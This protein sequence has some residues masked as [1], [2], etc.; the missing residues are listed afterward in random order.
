MEKIVT[1]DNIEL[2][3]V[4]N[5][6]TPIYY[7]HCFHKDMISQI[8][9]FTEINKR[10]N[11]LKKKNP[12]MEKEEFQKLLIDELSE[13][14][15]DELAIFSNEIIPQFV[16]VFNMQAE[17]GLATPEFLSERKFVEW[18]NQFG[19]TSFSRNNEIQLIVFQMWNSNS[20]TLSTSKN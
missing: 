19:I 3:L 16:F 5:A 20:K 15:L 13:S 14:E 17:H 8:T 10:I 1:I 4:S 2:K 12:N 18:L 11:K 9:K 7:K 6:A